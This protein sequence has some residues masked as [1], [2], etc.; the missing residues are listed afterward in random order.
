LVKKEF[1]M[2]ELQRIK[3]NRMPSTWMIVASLVVILLIASACSANSTDAPPR[4]TPTP[5][6]SQ[7]VSGGI[8]ANGTLLPARQ[9]R[10]SFG[11]G[12]FLIDRMVGI[13]DTVSS[14]HT[15]ASLDDSKA[16]LELAAAQAALQAAQAQ[17]TLAVK[18]LAASD[19][20]AALV[21]LEAQAELDA[22]YEIA[23]LARANALNEIVQ[24]S[25]EVEVAQYRLYYFTTPASLAELKPLDALAQTQARLMQART[26]FEPYKNASQNS[27]MRQQLKDVL[28][29]AQGDYYAAVRRLE[30]EAEM[31]EAQARLEAAQMKFESLTDGPDPDE[32]TMAEAR[33]AEAQASLNL[34]GSEDAAS[35]HLALAQAQV[36]SAQSRLAMAQAQLEMMELVTPIDGIVAS[37][38][39]EIGEWVIPGTPVI[40]L[41]D[42]SG[43]RVETKNVGE[44]QIGRVEAG[45][46]VRVWVNAFPGEVL[47]GR[48][49][50][51]APDAVVQQGDITFT[52]IIELEPTDLKLRPGMTARVEILVSEQ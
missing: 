33:V 1:T 10:L 46:E 48:V 23:D 34:F 52:L 49:I 14:G 20:A 45:Q 17:Y 9:V 41:V 38:D 42:T 13:G 30:L 28:D 29:Q 8:K 7:A 4:P 27:G 21:L 50:S 39:F 24:A 31:K 26:D 25:R 2:I 43:W 18:E 51:I 11:V 16:Q 19:E 40:E 12:G 5:L 37:L 36:D 35:A 32:V 47:N 44:L 15:L 6:A 22:L 3:S